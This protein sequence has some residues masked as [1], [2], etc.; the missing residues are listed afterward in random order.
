[1]S[2]A[3]PAAPQPRRSSRGA[4]LI[5]K[6]LAEAF[7][8]VEMLELAGHAL[9]AV[10]GIHAP[11]GHIMPPHLVKV[12]DVARAAREALRAA[13]VA[14]APRVVLCTPQEAPGFLKVANSVEAPRG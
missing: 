12:R 10:A 8:P 9:D 13:L 2:N 4:D 14:E 5:V 11:E 1:M 7:S 6:G 3:R